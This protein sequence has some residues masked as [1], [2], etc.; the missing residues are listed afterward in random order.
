LPI[1]RLDLLQSQGL[2]PSNFALL[3]PH[4]ILAYATL[5]LFIV[6]PGLIDTNIK[7]VLDRYE[8]LI[9]RSPNRVRTYLDRGRAYLDFGNLDAASADFDKAIALAPEN[10]TARKAQRWILDRKAAVQ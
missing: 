5:A 1:A 3:L 9:A 8:R 2:S 6:V 10:Q 7:A 4:T